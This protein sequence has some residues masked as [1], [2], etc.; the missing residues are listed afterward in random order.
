MKLS[1]MILVTLGFLAT[2]SYACMILGETDQKWVGFPN[3]FTVA[4]IEATTVFSRVNFTEVGNKDHALAQVNLGNATYI[5]MAIVG[6]GGVFSK[7]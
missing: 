7:C 6:G 1:V 3:E 2:N 5:A 4:E